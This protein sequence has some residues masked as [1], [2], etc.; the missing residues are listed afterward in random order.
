MLNTKRRL[1][2]NWLI[3]PNLCTRIVDLLEI[4]PGDRI[5]EIGSGAGALTTILAKLPISL[6]VIEIDPDCISKTQAE[7]IDPVAKITYHNQDFRDFNYDFSAK[8]ISNL[9]YHLTGEFWRIIFRPNSLLSTIVVMMQR[10]VANNL[11]AKAPNNTFLSCLREIF[12]SIDSS[13][14]VKKGNFRPIP[15][16]DS[17]VL[18]LSRKYP[19]ISDAQITKLIQWIKTG[20]VQKRKTVINNLS[21]LEDKILLDKTLSNLGH[22]NNVRAQELSLEDWLKIVLTK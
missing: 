21:S 11:A 17:K 1:S 14:L 12:Y 22:T 9:P 5:I 8:L 7:I 4:N 15:K 16:V 19:E 10:E 13:I 2:Q 20:Y 6:D 3:N 18:K